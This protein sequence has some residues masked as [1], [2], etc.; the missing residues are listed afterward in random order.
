MF[1]NA[2]TRITSNLLDV[3]LVIL[4]QKQLKS[5]R[6]GIRDQRLKLLDIVE[7]SE[8]TTKVSV[9]ELL[10]AVWRWSTATVKKIRCFKSINRL[11]KNSRS[12]VAVKTLSFFRQ[13]ERQCKSIVQPYVE[14][15]WCNPLKRFWRRKKQG[16]FAQN[17]HGRCGEIYNKF[18]LEWLFSVATSEVEN[19]VVIDLVGIFINFS[20]FRHQNDTEFS[21]PTQQI[22]N[23]KLLCPA[24]LLSK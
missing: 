3:K 24:P 22:L 5:Q 20:L 18:S 21:T 13:T 12:L 2:Q 9:W 6:K 11:H 16:Q 8:L 23:L 19:I 1:A 17:M 14:S 4:L 15:F 7:Y 10:R